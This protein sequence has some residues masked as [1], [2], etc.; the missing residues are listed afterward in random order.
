VQVALAVV[1]VAGASLLARSVWR[2]Q[3]APL[4]FEPQGAL[5]LEVSVPPSATRTRADMR[6]LHARVIERVQSLPGSTAVGAIQAL[7]LTDAAWSANVRVEGRAFLPNQAPDVSWRVASSGYFEA[8]RIPLLRGRVFTPGDGEGTPAVAVVNETLARV[9][10]PREDPLGHRIGTGL[11]GEDALATV[12][13]VVGDTPQSAPRVPPR[14]EMYRPLT[15]ETRYSASSMSLVVR[16]AGVPLEAAPAA[17]RA[18]WEVDPSLPITKVQPLADLARLS[19]ARE[20]VVGAF[21]ALFGALALFLAAL[22]LYGVLSCLVSERLREFAVR[23]ALGASPRQVRRL[24]LRRGLVL[25]GVGAGVGLLGALVLSG[26]LAS[27]LFEV[28]PTDPLTHA[29]VVATLLAAGALAAW[30]P[31]RRATRADPILALKED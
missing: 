19:I 5:A 13:G 28:K 10:W 14:P 16:T 12:V 21:L 30:L 1:L 29:A 26:T 23:I 22:G 2:L 24:V 7:P 15:Q 31:A 9:L 4:G 25:V 11:D 3:R 27:L 20:R 6:A 18:I 8:M 17:R